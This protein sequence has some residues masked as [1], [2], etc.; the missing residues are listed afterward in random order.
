MKTWS[1]LIN[2][3]FPRPQ[4]PTHPP[5]QNALFEKSPLH[6]ISII[7]NSEK[8]GDHVNMLTNDTFGFLLPH[9]IK[10]VLSIG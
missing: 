4:N 8:K 3:S 5:T 7:T 2:L 1:L 9:V 6:I 10:Y